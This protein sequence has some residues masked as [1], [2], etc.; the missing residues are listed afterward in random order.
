MTEAETQMKEHGVKM[1]V[2]PRKESKDESGVDLAFD[3]LMDLEENSDLSNFMKTFMEGSNS[4]QELWTSLDDTTVQT[5]AA[6]EQI[7]R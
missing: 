3:A 7:L 6:T 4:A 1:I 5:H 2:K